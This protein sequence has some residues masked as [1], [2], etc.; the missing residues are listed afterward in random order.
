MSSSAKFNIPDR[1]KSLILVKNLEKNIDEYE[2]QEL[3]EIKPNLILGIGK[4]YSKRLKR[5]ANIE[6]IA[7]LAQFDPRN[8]KEIGVSQKLLEKWTLSASIIYRYAVGAEVPLSVHRVC[9]AGL[10]APTARET[11]APS[12]S[13]ALYVI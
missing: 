2:K 9:I 12:L 8:A 1:I 13:H 6:T 4:Y 3:A 10:G 5:K 11:Q 7:G